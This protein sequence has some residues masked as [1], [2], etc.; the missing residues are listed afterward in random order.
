MTD[1][2]NAEFYQILK[3]TKKKK[4][5]NQYSSNCSVIQKTKQIISNSLYEASSTIRSPDR[6]PPPKKKQKKKKKKITGQNID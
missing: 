2:F 3:N 5:K 4:Q 1:G 6:D